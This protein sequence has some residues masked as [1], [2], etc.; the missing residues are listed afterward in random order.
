[1]HHDLT[2]AE[3]GALTGLSRETVSKVL[4]DLAGQGLLEVGSGTIVVT[5]EDALRRYVG[6]YT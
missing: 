5:D 2:Q 4:A 3:L 6:P 1:V